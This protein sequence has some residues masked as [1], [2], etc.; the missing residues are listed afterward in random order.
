MAA[1][2]MARRQGR[3]HRLL[4]IQHSPRHATGR[5]GPAGEDPLADRTRLPR[6]Q[7]RPRP[8]PLRRPQLHRLAPPRHPHRARASLL[9]DAGPGP[10]S[11]CAGLTLYAV[12]RELQHLLA[13]ITG[14][15]HTRGQSTDPPEPAPT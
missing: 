13:V 15:C 7:D 9:H 8:G 5:T 3:T 11:P 4:A 2:P 14:A 10:K 6:T 1:R 12:L